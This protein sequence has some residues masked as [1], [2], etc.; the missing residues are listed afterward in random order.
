MRRWG[1]RL[2]IYGVAL[3]AALVGVLGLL[4]TL[5]FASTLLAEPASVGFFGVSAAA[6]GRAMADPVVAGAL[7]AV[8]L[9]GIAA[10]RYRAG[11]LRRVGSVALEELAVWVGV[12]DDPDTLVA[13]AVAHE[14]LRW[15]GRRTAGGR[16]ELLR[17]ECPTCGLELVET[18]LPHSAAATGAERDVSPDAG[19]SL[20]GGVVRADPDG[21]S[22]MVETLACPQCSFTHPG[23]KGQMAERQSVV[24]KFRELFGRMEGGG[25]EPFERWRVLARERLGGE[26]A[27]G[28]LWDEYALR[29]D[30]PAVQPVNV[31]DEDDT[32][33][34]RAP[35]GTYP[36][37]E[38]L[39]RN[40]EGVD[41]VIEV[42]PSPFDFL[43]SKLVRSDYL[44][45]R[46]DLRERRAA[47]RST[48]VRRLGRTED[49]FG[50][51]LQR[52]A[53]A[54]AERRRPDDDPGRLVESL[55]AAREAI[56]SLQADLDESLLTGDE[57]RRLS[58]V[59]RDAERAIAYVE[60]VAEYREWR[61]GLESALARF[62][63]RYEP[64]ED[65][66]RY[67]LEAD[68]AALQDAIEATNDHVRDGMRRFDLDRLPA[69]A[70]TRLRRLDRE[71]DARE[72]LVAGYNERFLQRQR[73]KYE[74]VLTS[75]Y[76]ELNE[77]QQLAVVRDDRHNLVD[78]SAGT[79]KT[80]TL[81]HRFLYLVRRGVPP[82]DIAAITFTGDAAEE[83]RERIASALPGVSEERLESNVSTFHS[84][85]K[86]LVEDAMVGTLEQRVDGDEWD[87]EAAYR[88][89]AEGFVN[90]SRD[91]RDRHPTAL[92][93]FREHHKLFLE[94]DPDAIEKRARAAGC[95]S[96]EEFAVEKYREFL[97]KARDFDRTHEEIRADL[98]RA[99]QLQYRFGMA[100]CA[101]LKA[102][103]DRA[104]E[105]D[106]ALDFTDVLNSAT[107]IGREH[108][109]Y[110]GGMFEH[111]LFDEFQD[112][113]EPV[114]EFLETLL[115]GPRDTHL[116]AVGD[117][118]Q[119]IYGFRG[120]T[121]RYFM[122]FEERFDGVAD[123]TLGINYRCP[124]QVVSA[125]TELMRHG[126][127]DQNEKD[128][129]VDP[130]REPAPDPVVH[131]L[132]GFY[133]FR[134]AHYTADLVTGIV[135]RGADPGEVMVLS[136]NDASP[137]V[138]DLRERLDGRG[139]DVG[140]DTGVR[141]QTIHKA[142]GT[143]APHV[144]LLDAT[145]GTPHGLPSRE[146]TDLLV[147]PAVDDTA[148]YY[149]EERRLCYVALTRTEER[150]HVV[151]DHENPSR[152]LE[153]V[154]GFF[155]HRQETVSAIEG[156][157]TEWNVPD[158]DRRPIKATLDCGWATV[159]LM[160]FQNWDY[161]ELREGHRYRLSD[162]EIRDNGFG[163]EVEL[164]ADLELEHLGRVTADD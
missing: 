163:A 6:I 83:M 12:I 5:A 107:E 44:D 46:S 43:L 2:S 53:V 116:F 117:D 40:A 105:T 77:K 15:V 29:A 45:R 162:V 135:D 69:A 100:G 24:S 22:E 59:E 142:K 133:E 86:G 62:E 95:R 127:A 85:A 11:R 143:E 157:V 128:V 114:L 93:A 90:G 19:G 84:L 64:Y 131:E 28:D 96:N 73:E 78:A 109:E 144:V 160:A 9:G 7:V 112:V 55:R 102:F 25:D 110:V 130:E 3:L 17:R 58:H 66:D 82:D 94:A 149:A 13:G 92:E 52:A 154:G 75:E 4:S 99:N 104:A 76:G 79:G 121:P 158:A 136:R 134:V 118:W 151:T 111:V 32:E 35:T 70:E 103:R 74:A 150:L 147:D 126:E 141:V 89:Y 108:P 21:T 57:R 37:L 97:E 51:E 68:E 106:V 129:G 60:L 161:P 18:H 26:P 1:V 48:F 101:I 50:T 156:V 164:D 30:D 148:D 56:R 8:V 155:E 81:T 137:Y 49:S 65:G 140:G 159:P 88:R 61:E 36:A 16:I 98:T 41:R 72:R 124:S 87:P 153:D 27:P 34:E 14:G 146:K 138:K 123:T 120:S 47:V 145:D 10:V 139:V 152:Y 23:E 54:R 119:S 115:A 20:L 71:F 113:A 33:P 125:G 67:M 80:L 91:M 38:R 63:E 122:E 132:D 39:R 42:A 31:L